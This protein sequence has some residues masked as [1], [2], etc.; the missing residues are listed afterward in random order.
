MLIRFLVTNIYVKYH[1]LLVKP[2]LF[3]SLYIYIQLNRYSY[4]QIY[5]PYLNKILFLQFIY[6]ICSIICRNGR[7]FS[8]EKNIVLVHF[9]KVLRNYQCVL[10]FK[11][12]YIVMSCNNLGKHHLSP[13]SRYCNNINGLIFPQCEWYYTFKPGF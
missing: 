10:Y 2:T 11:S 12:N 13:L 9:P 8:L 1:S 5:F 6:I 7:M 4:L 3:T